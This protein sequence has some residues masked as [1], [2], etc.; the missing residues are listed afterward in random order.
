MTLLGINLTVSE[1]NAM[2]SINS[3]S[4]YRETIPLSFNLHRNKVFEHVNSLFFK[5]KSSY[6]AIFY[7]GEK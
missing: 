2:I 5:I 3:I 6:S 4:K 7:S 1:K